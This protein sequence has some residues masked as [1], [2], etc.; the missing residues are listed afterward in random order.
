M[1]IAIYL[2]NSDRAYRHSIV[3]YIYIC[4]RSNLQERKTIVVRVPYI[5]YQLRIIARMSCWDCRKAWV[6]QKG[7]A[8]SITFTRAMILQLA[9]QL[10]RQNGFVCHV[11]ANVY[12]KKSAHHYPFRCPF[13]CVRISIAMQNLSAMLSIH[14]TYPLLLSSPDITIVL[15][16]CG[17][18]WVMEYTPPLSE[19]KFYQP[20]SAI[21]ADA[22]REHGPGEIT[23]CDYYFIDEMKIIR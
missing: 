7:S 9:R 8:R 11:N 20:S 1:K 19:S 6:L 14:R 16:K 22:W 18:N 17:S 4:I 3:Q 21:A 23:R 5:G 10:W 2:L 13:L 12:D 15:V